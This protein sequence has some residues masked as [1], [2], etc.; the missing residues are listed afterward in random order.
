MLHISSYWKKE[1]PSFK[2][3][4]ESA[5]T[6]EL[7]CCS[8]WFELHFIS[9]T[10]SMGDVEAQLQHSWTFSASSEQRWFS[11]SQVKN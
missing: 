10:G 3:Y 6:P 7:C 5:A 9:I 2:Q 8:G 4:L 11:F 1:G